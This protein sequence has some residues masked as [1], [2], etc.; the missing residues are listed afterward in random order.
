MKTHLLLAVAACAAGCTTPY[1]Q[2]DGRRYHQVPIDTYPVV[3]SKV[4]GE[5]YLRQPVLV[6]PGPR[7]IVV[8]GPPTPTNSYGA[9]REFDL[10]VKPCT[11]YYLVAVK[12]SPLSND[13]TVKVDEEVPLTQCSAAATAAEPPAPPE[14]AASA[15]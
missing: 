15:P 5:S 14:A 3:I 6:E 1:S 7:K 13:F 9:L 10:D 4:D 11:R 12:R 8:Q 2:L